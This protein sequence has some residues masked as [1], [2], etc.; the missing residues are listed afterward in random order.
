[1]SKITLNPVGSLIDTTTAANT[2]NVNSVTVQ[3]AIDNTI[4][5]DGTSPNQMNASLDMNSNT[6]INVGDGVSPSDAA[7]LRLL[8]KVSTVAGNMAVGGSTT[9]VLTKASNATYDTVWAT[10]SAIVGSNFFG[11]R[12][13]PT[14]GVT[15]LTGNATSN[16]IWYSPYN[17]A[18]IAV[19]GI[20][21]SF[22]SSSGDQNGWSLSIAG[23]ATGSYHVCSNGSGLYTIPFANTPV[24]YF[25][26]LADPNATTHP[27]LGSIT[28][29]TAGVVT[30]HVTD[31]YNRRWEVYNY[32]NQ[33]PLMLRVL[34][35]ERD[36][37]IHVT[38]H[39]SSLQP[40]NNNA[41]NCGS[42]FTGQ[43]EL[44]NVKWM[45]GTFLNTQTLA[46]G[47]LNTIGW[48]S[49]TFGSG[50]W[51]GGTIDNLGSALGAPLIAE[52]TNPNAVGY[53]KATMLIGTSNVPN[54]IN[55]AHS[56][57]TPAVYY[58]AETN[59][60]MFIRWNG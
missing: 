4:S 22:L 49:T 59:N 46:G 32:Y 51:G 38:N 19:N 12:L 13:T 9:Q 52:Y 53:N 41:L 58:D 28:L 42:V 3:N 36:L 16:T 27:Y 29:S 21:T 37:D 43:N 24:K 20:S 8:N 45:E 39:Y 31:D 40:F 17:G 6:I 50:R 60:V 18:N 30:C 25:G 23:L 11:G 48:N 26:A 2:I 55:V 1:M 5:R 7:N 54:N 34:T 57:S 33:Q 47:I 35:Q 15:K 56:S 10:P 44:V 14:A